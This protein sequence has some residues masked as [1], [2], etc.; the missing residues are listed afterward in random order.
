MGKTRKSLCVVLPYAFS[1]ASLICLIFANLTGFGSTLEKK[2]TGLISQRS[3]F[4]DSLAAVAGSTSDVSSTLQDTSN[5]AQNAGNSV[6]DGVMGA[7]GNAVDE[8]K[9]QAQDVSDKL[10]K[11]E[12]NIE[13]YYI[14]G[15][16]GYCQGSFNETGSTVRKCTPPS[17]SFWF[18]FTEVLGLESSW[19]EQIF[20]SQV[21]KVVSV[22]KVASKGISATY[23]T[24]LITTVLTLI[25][26]LTAM[27]SHWGSCLVSICALISMVSNIAGS[28][29]VTGVYV[30]LVGV[31][32]SVFYSA[33]INAS[34][35]QKMLATSWLASS[36][37]VVA[38]ILWLLSIC[39]W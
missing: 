13:G 31:L 17:S 8:A 15:L 28:A 4:D 25:T 7:V 35:G 32:K 20:P 10:A 26:G 27:V 30:S 3:V 36:F 33:G 39:C 2:L 34:L 21:E 38:C 19:A 22:Y 23:I 16:W 5:T 9:N 12:S 11:I 18:N 14:I 1:V 24:A 6:I 29:T 37:S